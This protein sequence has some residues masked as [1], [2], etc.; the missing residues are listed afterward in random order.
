[1]VLATAGFTVNFSCTIAHLVGKKA[2]M[3]TERFYLFWES[4]LRSLQLF[5]ARYSAFHLYMAHLKV[6]F[7]YKQ[8]TSLRS[9]IS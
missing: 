5:V 6:P 2:K 7:R 1:M 8:N 9:C 3:Y 4:F